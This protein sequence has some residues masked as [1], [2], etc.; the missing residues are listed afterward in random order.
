MLDKKEKETFMFYFTTIIV[1]PALIAL[2]ILVELE[3]KKESLCKN[4]HF[5]ELYIG[6]GMYLLLL[7]LMLLEKANAVE[8]IFGLAILVI[9]VINIIV[10]I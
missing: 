8:I 1:L 6:K 7:S 5:L 9:C 2:F 4:F 3:V 10:G